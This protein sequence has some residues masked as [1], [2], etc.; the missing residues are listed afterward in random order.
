[1]TTPPKAKQIPHIFTEFGD[2]RTFLMNLAGV[3]A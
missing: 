1:M 3:P 2:K